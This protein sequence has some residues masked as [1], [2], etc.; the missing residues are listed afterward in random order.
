[1]ALKQEKYVYFYGVVMKSKIIIH[2]RKCYDFIT[3]AI[4]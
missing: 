4:Y 2:D 1:M 3:L